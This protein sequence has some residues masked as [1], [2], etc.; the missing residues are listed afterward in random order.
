MSLVTDRTV[1]AE[2]ERIERGD[3]H[4]VDKETNGLK[5]WAGDRLVGVAVETDGEAAYFGFRHEGGGNVPIEYLPKL[6]RA[7]RGRGNKRYRGWNIRYDFTMASYEE[8]G[9]WC[10]NAETDDGIVDALLMNENEPSFS[11]ANM[12]EKY[13]GFGAAASK[14][15]MDRLL[16][17]RFSKVRSARDRKGMLWKLPAREVAEY[18]CGDVLLPLRLRERFAPALENWGLTQL[19]REMNQYNLLLARMQKTGI[20]IDVERCRHLSET[21]EARKAELLEKVRKLAG[22]GCHQLNPNSWQQVSKLLGT[23]DAKEKTLERLESELARGVVDYKKLG[24]AKSAYY[25]AILRL[26]DEDGYLH[27]QLNMSRDPSDTG[28]TKTGRL[29]C[30]DPNFQ[31]LPQ[32]DDDPNAIYQVRDLVLPRPGYT[33]LKCD[34]ERAEVW[35]SASYAQEPKLIAAYHAGED[36]Y[37]EMSARLGITRK[38]AKLLHLMTTYGAG[39]WKIALALGWDQAKAYDVR[40]AFFA[41]Y[42]SLKQAMWGYADAWEGTGSLRLWTGRAIHYPGERSYAAWNRVLQGAVGE[43]VRVAMQRLEPVIAGCG[44]RMLL[45]THDEILIEAPTENVAHTWNLTKMIMEDFDQFL[46]RPRVDIRASAE[47]YARAA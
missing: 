41:T 13:L 31:A 7:L 45:Q 37:V 34:Y 27:P 21:T 24:K 39:P 47:N 44:A 46:L 29:S 40:A 22:P 33:L 8:G 10:L 30:S 28:G 4:T 19:A 5:P 43:M 32:A 25:D 26:I 23:V 20:Q 16:D 18:A 35:M 2:L 36:P 12:A 11:L 1:S 38:Q 6:F 14:H 9:E 3:S 15:K 17:E 42:P